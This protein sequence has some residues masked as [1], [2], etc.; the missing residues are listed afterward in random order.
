M[1]TNT[2]MV[3]SVLFA[4]NGRQPFV[5]CSSH[6]GEK[7]CGSRY[8]ALKKIFQKE[9]MN[10]VQRGKRLMTFPS[11]I[12]NVNYIQDGR[13]LIT[14][15]LDNVMFLRSCIAR[16]YLKYCSTTKTY[17]LR[18]V[19]TLVF[20]EHFISLVFQLTLIK[21]RVSNM[22]VSSKISLLHFLEVN[23]KT[24]KQHRQ[25]IMENIGCGLGATPYVRRRK[26]QSKSEAWCKVK[27][28]T[29]LKRCEELKPIDQAE[30]SLKIQ[31][32]RKKRQKWKKPRPFDP[33]DENGNAFL[34]FR[35]SFS[36]CPIHQSSSRPQNSTQARR[37]GIHSQQ[38][39]Q[40]H[41][42]GHL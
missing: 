5:W 41:F 16:Q 33:R 18:F 14:V 37:K 36:P 40:S 4:K 31:I 39:S 28:N 21:K 25:Q 38:T 30:H 22:K 9:E 2:N 34:G 19:V 12:Y 32:E 27:R 10:S 23:R 29:Y 13:N 24:K 15:I 42:I 6:F 17:V 7:L 26:K 20:L 35:F 3:F 11:V 1:R 8:K